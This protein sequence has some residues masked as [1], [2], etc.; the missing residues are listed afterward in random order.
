MNHNAGKSLTKLLKKKWK[1]RGKTQIELK[2][3][4]IDAQYK[5]QPLKGFARGRRKVYP[6]TGL[7]RWDIP[8]HP[9]KPM[10]IKSSGKWV[11]TGKKDGLYQ[12][13]Y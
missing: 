10:M 5:V 13:R 7:D 4:S 9:C 8:I 3:L 12:A 6:I 1:R 11:K 2:A